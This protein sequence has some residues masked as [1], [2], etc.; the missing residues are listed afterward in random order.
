[1]TQWFLPKL[2]LVTKMLIEVLSQLL[3]DKNNE[4]KSASSKLELMLKDN[5]IVIAL[6]KSSGRKK[7]EITWDVVVQR[8][9]KFVTLEIEKASSS[10]V[11]EKRAKEIANLYKTAIRTAER[12]NTILKPGP[13]F[14]HIGY[15]IERVEKGSF[16]EIYSNILVKLLLPKRKHSNEL[17]P[18]RWKFFVELF[19]QLLE[20][21]QSHQSAFVYASALHKL[22][23]IVCNVPDVDTG[24][25]STF[26]KDIFSTKRSKENVSFLETMISS[27]NLFCKAF[28]LECQAEIC[29]LGDDIFHFLLN[30]WKSQ[31]A[32]LK[33]Q[34]L[35]FFDVQ[36]KT[37]SINSSETDLDLY[38]WFHD[39]WK[40][41]MKE[42]FEVL[43]KEMAQISK[44][45]KSYQKKLISLMTQLVGQLT[46]LNVE[47]NPN[48]ENTFESGENRRK[49][50]RLSD[51]KPLTALLMGI[52]FVV[53]PS[54]SCLI[55]KV[56]SSLMDDQSF[57]IND[58]T[59]KDILNK[60]ANNA[61]LPGIDVEHKNNVLLH[62]IA[63]ASH[64]CVQTKGESNDCNLEL[65]KIFYVCHKSMK[66]IADQEKFI[67]FIRTLIQFKV[68]RINQVFK[69]DDPLDQWHCSRELLILFLEMAARNYFPDNEHNEEREKTL[70]NGFPQRNMLYNWLIPPS[71][72]YQNMASSNIEALAH[73]VVMLTC[74]SPA[75]F[76]GQSVN[77]PRKSGKVDEESTGSVYDIVQKPAPVN[78]EKPI[79][80]QNM[81]EAGCGFLIELFTRFWKVMDT[82]EEKDNLEIH[83]TSLCL[84]LKVMVL[85][86]KHIIDTDANKHLSK[87]IRK[88]SEH[89]SV[90]LPKLLKQQSE[91]ERK[92]LVEGL[93]LFDTFLE[94]ASV[95]SI[96]FALGWNLVEDVLYSILSKKDSVSG[97][98]SSGASSST[99]DM[100]MEF[101]DS[102]NSDD[103]NNSNQDNPLT[104]ANVGEELQM[105]ACSIVCKV[106]LHHCQ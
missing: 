80:R 48:I 96:F 30:I 85:L 67:P 53:R 88:C 44:S 97:K 7:S 87:F 6:D 46:F 62:S 10:E 64:C 90:M 89:L 59:T 18:K 57:V 23:E 1:M 8:I 11:L 61:S 47:V 9:A 81:I 102:P 13:V 28:V 92:A 71:N 35:T 31:S 75:L 105:V 83:T 104:S 91:E 54:Q 3:S 36:L 78:M 58:T 2:I 21:N 52:D 70:L 26:F 84:C 39:A 37:H 4:R 27:M 60:I 99:D 98:W 14:N 103:T 69:R 77:V 20:A 5:E 95:C 101:D 86:K 51:E 66:S 56:I 55:L 29:A 72:P 79:K 100:M 40:A 76:S 63:V 82:V 73:L 25:L 41:N 93:S 106:C 50:Q 34:L 19:C 43:Y 24:K 42:L 16:L 32:S 33:N 22:M 17:G 38:P 74:K 49:R 12:N 15:V 65:L 45:K 68:L 94:D